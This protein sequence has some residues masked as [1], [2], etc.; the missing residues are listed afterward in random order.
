[1]LRIPRDPQ[2]FIRG[3]EAVWFQLRPAPKGDPARP[4]AIRV[5]TGTDEVLKA[6]RPGAQR[7]SYRC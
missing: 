1:M 2:C 3:Q 6:R 7:P 4:P 5:V